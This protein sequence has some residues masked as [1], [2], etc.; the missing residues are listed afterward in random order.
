MKNLIKKWWFWFIIAIVIIIASLGIKNYIE[1]KEIERKFQKMS[2]GITD[3]YKGTQEAEGYLNRFT[4]NY[5]T[6]KVDY[7]E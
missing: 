5:S 2:E 3:Y 1:N 6:G 4:Y 7:T